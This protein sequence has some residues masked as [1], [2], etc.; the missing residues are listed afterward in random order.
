MV[1]EEQCPSCDAQTYIDLCGKKRKRINKNAQGEFFK[2][3]ACPLWEPKRAPLVHLQVC[4]TCGQSLPSAGEPVKTVKAEA[5]KLPPPLPKVVLTPERVEEL[6][7]KEKESQLSIPGVIP[8]EFPAIEGS[9]PA[10][11]KKPRKRSAG[12][13]RARKEKK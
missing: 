3:I 4:P 8:D 5:V 11:S 13:K 1:A 7:Q 12:N 2:S 6:V 10:S 9:D